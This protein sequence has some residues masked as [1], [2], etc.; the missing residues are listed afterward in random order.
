MKFENTCPSA[1]WSLHLLWGTCVLRL[2]DANTQCRCRDQRAD[3]HFRRVH[4]YSAITFPPLLSTVKLVRYYLKLNAL[5][6]IQFVA[7]EVK[8]AHV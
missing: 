1:L 8:R 6:I 2:P 5:D 4:Q 3:G 7:R